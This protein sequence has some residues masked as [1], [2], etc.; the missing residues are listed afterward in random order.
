M[1]RFLLKLFSQYDGFYTKPPMDH[2]KKYYTKDELICFCNDGG[3]VWFG[4]SDSWYH[5]MKHSEFRSVIWWYLKTWA[6]K[7]FFGL[8][9]FIYYKLLSASTNQH[10]RLERP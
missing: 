8:R 9:T 7:D 4:R 1:I 6:F 3:E 2:L 10:K 5:F